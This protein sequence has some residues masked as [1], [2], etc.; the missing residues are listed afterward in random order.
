MNKIITE[1]L[2][3]ESAIKTLFSKVDYEIDHNYILV[4]VDDRTFIT[5]KGDC[6]EQL[7]KSLMANQKG[8]K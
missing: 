7:I 3:I 2:L 1:I 8:V 5:Y 6:P 4:R